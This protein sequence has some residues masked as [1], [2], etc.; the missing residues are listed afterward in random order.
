MHQPASQSPSGGL[1]RERSLGGVPAFLEDSP[2]PGSLNAIH[3]AV[4]P[5]GASGPLWL[6][7][8]M[9]P[10]EVILGNV[11][12]LVALPALARI[13]GPAIV[14]ALWLIDATL[15]VGLAAAVRRANSEHDRR[16]A[17]ALVSL[18][19]AAFF[20]WYAVWVAGTNATGFA[21]ALAFAVPLLALGNGVG[22]AI[23]AARSVDTAP[24]SGA[25]MMQ[26]AN[27]VETIALEDASHQPTA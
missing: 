16:L 25:P 23:R 8:S 19:V 14:P 3:G 12:L 15:A 13:T 22:S 17:T 11:A 18:I 21:V 2:V 4:A 10:A 26:L 20:D 5:A 1:T 7:P 6:L 24:R 9:I 27:G